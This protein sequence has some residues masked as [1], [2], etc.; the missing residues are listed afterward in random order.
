MGAMGYFRPC[1][2]CGSSSAC[3][4]DCACAKCLDPD[5]YARWKDENPQ[6]YEEW[7]HEQREPDEW[8]GD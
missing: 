1:W 2:S 4:P 6:E 8:I 7:L 5:D 3:Y